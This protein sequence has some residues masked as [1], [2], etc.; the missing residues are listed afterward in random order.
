MAKAARTAGQERRS[1]ASINRW[2]V[3]HEGA[4]LGPDY[5]RTFAALG[6]RE[7]LEEIELGKG[8]DE[9]QAA[10]RAEA[11]RRGLEVGA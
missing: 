8:G 7:L 6:D 11:A 4:M 1:A 3:L 10:A 2:S 9:F 5:S